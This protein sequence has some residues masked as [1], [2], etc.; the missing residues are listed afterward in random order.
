MRVLIVGAGVIGTVP[1]AAAPAAARVPTARLSRTNPWWLAGTRPYGVRMRRSAGKIGS[2][3]PTGPGTPPGDASAPAPSS[4]AG[5]VCN[6]A[7]SRRMEECR[8]AL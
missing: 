7:A 3:G 5:V 2:S 8:S 6:A 4:E 1:P